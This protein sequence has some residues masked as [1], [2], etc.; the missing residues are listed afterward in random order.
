MAS[1]SMKLFGM[2]LAL[3]PIM[4]IS[5]DIFRRRGMK[6]YRRVR[7]SLSNI[8]ASLAE[9]IS[10]VRVAQAFC[11]ERINC[12][13]F[14]D[15]VLAHKKNVVSAAIVW[16]LYYPII[17]I[18]H[19]LSVVVAIIYGGGLISTG[20]L[21]I[22][23][24]SAF[25]MYSGMFFGPIM[26]LSDLYNGMLSGA[27]A[28]ERIFLLLDT[29]PS[30]KNRPNA[31][32]VNFI[33]G[34]IDFRNI[35][36]KY[37]QEGSLILENVSF[38]INP[39]ETVAIVGETGAGKTS[40]AGVHARFYEAESG[41][42]L[43]DNKPIED[44]K[45]ESLHSHMGVVLQE[46]FLFSGTVLENL[47]FGRPDATDNEIFDTAMQLGTYEIFSELSHGYNTVIK[48]QGKGRINPISRLLLST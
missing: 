44:F 32:D 3:I 4:L 47:R 22:G 5:T 16:N 10:G 29:E 30:V 1:Y 7:E 31:C 48:E 18:L 11:R 2:V 27:S 45:L 25:I 39:G 33:E 38:T 24:M 14:R 41:S 36:F 20:E 9:S 17:M 21:T 28:A 13:R 8:T 15:I 26:E 46:N 6:A 34:K 23:K 12:S 40:I 42:V 19:A 37:K 35:N 43:I